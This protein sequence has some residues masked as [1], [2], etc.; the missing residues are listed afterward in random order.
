MNHYCFTDSIV[1]RLVN[2]Y[3][4]SYEGRVEVYY[5]GIWG[6]VYIC[7]DG[8]D[9]KVAEVVCRELR[10]GPAISVRREV[11]YGQ[12]SDQIF[13]DKVNCVGTEWTTSQ[14]SFRGW[15]IESCQYNGGVQASVKCSDPKGNI[16]P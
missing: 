15:G 14:C 9:L 12:G 10:Y 8:L 3:S 13:L 16:F 7:N 2:E 1:I 5:N 11:F 6:T 4:S